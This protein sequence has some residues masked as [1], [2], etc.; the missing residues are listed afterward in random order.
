MP[1]PLTYS[2]I[3]LAGSAPVILLLTS[4]TL[5]VFHCRKRQWSTIDIFLVSIL[6]QNFVQ[7]FLTFTYALLSLIK[8]SPVSTGDAA[9]AGL[10]WFF[11]TIPIFKG[12]TVAS[13]AVDRCLHFS[14]FGYR[15]SVQKNHIRYHIGVLAV[16]SCV[17]GFTALLTFNNPELLRD[18]SWSSLGSATYSFDK[19]TFI[20][21]KFDSKFVIFYIIIHVII[22]LTGLIAV[23][24]ASSCSTAQ[25]GGRK[26]S[27]NIRNK[28]HNHNI[29]PHLAQKGR[30]KRKH[31]CPP[32]DL[33]PT[34]SNT[35]TASS[36]ISV[37]NTLNLFSTPGLRAKAVL[38]NLPS[39][40]YQL[41]NEILLDYNEQKKEGN[42]RRLST[43][44]GLF[45]LTCVFTHLPLI[46]AT[47]F[48][49][50]AL[51]N[52]EDLP[53]TLKWPI[54]NILLWCQVTEGLIT[55]LILLT[56]D[57]IVPTW[58]FN[59]GKKCSKKSSMQ[60][61][62]P[63]LTNV[64]DVNMTLTTSD[65]KAP[66][67]FT[68]PFQHQLNNSRNAI[69]INSSCLPI[70]QPQQVDFKTN[71]FPITNGSLFAS[72]TAAA[73][74]SSKGNKPVGRGGILQLDNATDTTLS[75]HPSNIYVSLTNDFDSF[76]SFD[77]V[78]T[79]DEDDESR[80][81]YHLRCASVTTVANDDFEFHTTANGLPMSYPSPAPTYSQATYVMHKGG[82]LPHHH[83]QNIPSSSSSSVTPSHQ[84]HNMAI[85]QQLQLPSTSSASASA[86]GFSN[87]SSSRAS[88]NHN[89][90]SS[91]QQYTLESN[92]S[93]RN[94]PPRNVI[95][96]ERPATSAAM[97]GGGGGSGQTSAS[98]HSQQ[99]T[100]LS[101]N[102][103][104]LIEE[105]QPLSSA[106]L[107]NMPT[108]SEEYKQHHQQP[109]LYRKRPRFQQHP[110]NGGGGGTRRRI[111]DS[112]SNV[113]FSMPNRRVLSLECLSPPKNQTDSPF[114]DISYLDT[115]DLCLVKQGGDGSRC[116]F[117]T[118]FL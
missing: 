72:L 45:L 65:M 37:D 11:I 84:H 76:A 8:L 38:S 113:L 1:A 102:D 91:S 20:P 109:R 118:D 6:S 96:R 80:Q 63:N 36:N 43:S 57:S 100:S 27:N 89:C 5:A 28:S 117:V 97:L 95:L 99:L 90:G 33:T 56:I 82:N 10:L 29:P 77:K 31:R 46:V 78:F 60:H 35:S 47:L 62:Q 112:S 98:H 16:L 50:F 110:Q 66:N 92:F 85:Q 58:I 105:M 64:T 3:A 49:R 116:I 7:Q 74:A 114:F 83:H 51:T 67:N 32:L 59:R 41:S 108:T 94:K 39:E 104:D 86:C 88:H 18:E 101:M 53:F 21:F 111:Q 106:E 44:G 26:G 48:S 14:K 19:C 30:L 23:W 34:L 22:V 79:G 52:A 61:Y 107:R 68:R 15:L 54:T 40:P 71:K 13:L 115:G 103:L 25:N 69:M 73:A 17:V 2:W 9:C 93:L 12:A 4:W 42:F 24:K 81:S 70:G 87:P 55:L 75:E